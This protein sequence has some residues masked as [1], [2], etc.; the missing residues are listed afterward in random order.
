MEKYIGKTFDEVFK[1]I[2]EN[3]SH[4]SYEILYGEEKS[5]G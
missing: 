1:E 4:W 2:K 5:T 3:Y